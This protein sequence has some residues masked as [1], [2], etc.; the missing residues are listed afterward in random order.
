MTQAQWYALYVM[1]RHEFVVSAELQRKGIRAFLPSVTKLRRWRDRKKLI[2]FPLFPGYVFVHLSPDPVEFVRTVRTRGTVSFV[3]LQAGTPTPIAPEEIDSLKIMLESGAPIDIYPELRVGS[4]VR[5]TK[6][7]FEGASGFLEKKNGQC[8][9]IVSIKL[10]G[11][12][13]GVPIHA[14]DL[15]AA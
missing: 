15:E 5:I 10:L 7:V 6:G 11:K 8:V 4:P 12:S 3:S 9:F 1:P 14:D 2:E 13:V